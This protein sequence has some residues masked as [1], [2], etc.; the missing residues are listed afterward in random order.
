M[1]VD[2]SQ[3]FAANGSNE[4]LQT[5]LLAYAGPGRTVATFEPTY[6]MH[7][8]IARVTGATV[9]EGER[10]A[11][12]TLDPAE[13]DACDQ[14]RTRT[15]C[16]C[17]RPTTRP[18]SSS[19]PTGARAARAR[20]ASWSSTRRTPSSPTGR[21]STLVDES[22]PLVVT[23]T[24]SK[25]WSMAGA[26]LGYLSARRGWSPNSTRWCC[27]TTSTPPSRSPVGSRCGSSTRWTPACDRS[28]PSASGSPRRCGDARRRRGAERRQ[29]RPVPAALASRSAGLAGARRPQ[30]ARPRL[31]GLAAARPTACA[32]PIGTREENDEFLEPRLAEIVATRAASARVNRT[33]KETSIDLTIDLD[34]IGRHRRLD[35]HPV[36]RPHAR[37]ARAPR[38]FRSARRTP[39]GDL[40]IDT[41]HTVEDVAISARR[42]VPPRR[43]AT[44]PACAG[45]PA[46]GTRS[47]RRSS[48]SPSTCRAARSSCGTS[49]CPSACRWQPG[50]RPAAR[51]ARGCL[52]RHRGGHHAARRHCVRGRN[53][54]HII[55]AM[56]KGL[57]RSLR[58]AVRVDVG[59]R[60][61]DEGRAVT[62]DFVSFPFFSQTNRTSLSGRAE[63]AE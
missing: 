40:H 47:T 20:P 18:D 31:L 48:T 1:I 29:L 25:T 33:T 54:H 23:R 7:A 19:R 32:S 3:V 44:R 8:H 12:F 42:G 38:W 2:P 28:S 49:R 55:E 16:S 60:A 5:L 24:F 50:V 37:P 61:V 45:S 52:V 39:I 51:R 10:A 62:G 21:R 27:R 17:A 22:T 58:D 46:V 15:S 11:D 30:R 14:R 35:R 53:V 43:S 41:H 57:A 56:F 13:V 4:V 6:Q 9:V 34:G 59:R 26:R 36:L 63:R